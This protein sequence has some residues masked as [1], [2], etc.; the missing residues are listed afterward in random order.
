MGKPT[1]MILPILCDPLLAYGENH[2]PWY[3][4]TTKLFRQ[5]QFGEWD[6]VFDQIK[7][8]LNTL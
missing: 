5:K 4:N 1:W 8:E 2:T 6:S 7:T 3:Q